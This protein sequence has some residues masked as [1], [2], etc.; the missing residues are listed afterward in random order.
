MSRWYRGEGKS[1]KS[2]SNNHPRA[3]GASAEDPMSEALNRIG[4][5]AAST[6]DC[7]HATIFIDDPSDSDDYM[8]DPFRKTCRAAD[9]SAPLVKESKPVP[10]V[11]TINPVTI[12]E[13]VY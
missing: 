4:D 2:V 6:S 8:E 13:S 10:P 7:A 9:T 12:S 11:S 5:L 1:T 3:A